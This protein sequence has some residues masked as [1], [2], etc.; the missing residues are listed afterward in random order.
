MA[1]P[2][3]RRDPTAVR[4]RSGIA[5]AIARS[6]RS[7][8]LSQIQA[9]RLVGGRPADVSHIVNGQ[10]AG[11]SLDRLIRTLTRLGHDVDL[12]IGTSSSEATGE[13]R[14]VTRAATH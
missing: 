3:S 13:V 5:E 2:T 14:L 9:A 12:I 1:N 8:G 10:L 11:L 6:I 7:R 4:T